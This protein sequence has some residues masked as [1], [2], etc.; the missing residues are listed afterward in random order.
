MSDTTNNKLNACEYKLKTGEHYA[1]KVISKKLMK[2]KEQMILNEINVLK[3]ISKGHKNIITLYDLYLVLDLCIG[4]ELFDRIIE[5]GQFYEKDAAKII[6]SVVDALKYLHHNNVIHRDIKPENLLFKNRDPES[7][8]VVAD[9][10][11]AVILDNPEKK[12]GIKTSC[13]TPGYMAPEMILKLGHSKPVDLWALGVMAFFLLSGCLP[14][15][16][17]D[18]VIENH[19]NCNAIYTFEPTLWS[20]VSSLAK[21]FIQ[22]LLV[23]DERKRLTAEQAYNHLWLCDSAGEHHGSEDLLPRVRKGF[24][25][26][27]MFKKAID[28]VKAVNKLSMH[29]IYSAKNS[30]DNLIKSSHSSKSDLAKDELLSPTENGFLNVPGFISREGSFKT[31]EES[32]PNPIAVTL[33]VIPDNK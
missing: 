32:I 23:V 10:G 5:T 7:D 28:V 26:R 17:D 30:V 20:S 21:E 27:K 18:E 33:S 14:F 24:D 2:G 15:E 8:I 9:F 16:N 11:L 3:K 6:K 29:S 12:H 31:P 19:N 4:G 1:A 13:G 22:Q 25:G